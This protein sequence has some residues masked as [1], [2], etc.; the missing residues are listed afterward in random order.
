LIRAFQNGHLPKFVTALPI[1]PE[2]LPTF[3]I[4]NY[5]VLGSSSLWD[6]LSPPRILNILK[7]IIVLRGSIQGRDAVAISIVEGF[8]TGKCGVFGLVAEP[9]AV[10][11][12]AICRGGFGSASRWINKQKGLPREH[13][14]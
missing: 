4:I 10:I 8:S 6:T 11:F 13:F 3:P 2:S 7:M 5:D 12:S 14:C 1:S 9:P